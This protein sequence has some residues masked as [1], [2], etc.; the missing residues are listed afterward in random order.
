M[1]PSLSNQARRGG[2]PETA[3]VGDPGAPATRGP[4]RPPARGLRVRCAQR[5]LAG[6]K[7]TNEDSLDF[8]LPEEPLRTTKGVVA[9]I[10]DGMSACQAG[11]EASR[12]AV[13]GF[14][15]DYYSTPESWSVQRA[16][17]RV[18][19]ALNRW[20]YGRGQALQG[21]REGLV[22]TLSCLV[23]KSHSAHLFHV[24]DSRIHRWREGELEQLTKDH[25]LRMRGQR[26]YLCRA[27]GIDAQ[28]EIDYRRLA[29]EPGDL[30][31]LT[32]D[33]V[34][35]HLDRQTLARILAEGGTPEERVQRILAQARQ[36]GSDDN[37]S[38]QVVQVEDLPDADGDDFYRR[39][40]ELPFPPPLEPG[41]VLDGYRIL[42]ELHATAHVQVYLA[43]DTVDGRRVVL[44]TPSVNHQDDPGY[45]DRFA[46]EEWIARRVDDPH[47]LKAVTGHHRRRFLYHVTE[48]IPGR[49]LRQW[50]DDH[51]R[52]SLAL[53][54]DILGQIAQGLRALHRLDM[55]HQDLKPDN[56]L[57]DE[58][59]TAHIIDFGST[60]VAGLEE[61]ATPLDRGGPAGTRDY[62]A[63]EYF[64]G[65]HGSRRS[66]IYS[67]GV[68]A[69]EI[70]TGQRPW[71]RPLNARNLGR[72]HY[73]PASR[74]NPDVP[75]WMDAALQKALAIDPE[76]RYQRLSEFI[77]DLSHPNPELLRDRP[78]PLL[79]RNPLAFWKWAAWLLGLAN[80]G[81]LIAWLW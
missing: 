32:T 53:A 37:L 36:A 31:L 66:D 33:G 39:L 24:G 56:I 77:H 79:E 11:A 76:R 75:A 23:L 16:G 55:V 44:K 34:H 81:W 50:L 46:H 45:I 2:T 15:H 12:C 25:R 43:L 9:A 60:L 65:W 38:C 62:A 1:S 57:I 26:D 47:V 70:L 73:R 3:Q 18:I 22:T 61:I 58:Q 13:V 20:L 28:V 10:A 41:M 35:D 69:Y 40:T 71:S 54:R 30:F 17:G 29:L 78:P 49:T 64:R 21:A 52:P 8:A 27:L 63:P 42:R 67:L 4:A 48:Y 59:G 72:V 5:S 19:T 74:F 51:P 80:L 6:I 68:I 14:L 7:A